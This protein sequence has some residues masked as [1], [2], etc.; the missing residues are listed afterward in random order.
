MPVL[1][2]KIITLDINT[3]DIRLLMVKGNFIVKWAS[4]PIT[5]GMVDGGVV[6][7][8]AILGLKIKQLMEASGITGNKII[9]SASGLYSISRIIHVPDSNGESEE[10]R[11]TNAVEGTWT[12][13]VGE[14]YLTWDKLI[15]NGNGSRAFVIGTPKNIID[16]QIASLK[17]I[18]VQPYIMNLK[19]TALLKLIDRENAVVIN[20][21]ADCLDIALIA[22]SI[23][24]IMRSVGRQINIDSDEWLQDVISVIDQTILFYDSRFSDSSFED[25]SLYISGALAE[26]PEIAERVQDL[27]QL[28][29][30]QL[31]IPFKYPPNLPIHKYAVNIGLAV[32]QMQFPRF[33]KIES[34]DADEIEENETEQQIT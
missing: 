30:T 17:Y 19:S 12:V 25:I 4:A 34:A 15:P 2:N 9:V 22:N 24:Q 13:P 10:Q 16:T 14:L 32:K 31:A 8:P 26:N 20:L 18:N 23:P 11:V 21:E 6:K 1:P 7:E 29:S 28:P 33:V 27:T 3:S 5:P